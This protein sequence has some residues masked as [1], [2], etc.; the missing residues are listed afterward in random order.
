MHCPEIT[1]AYGQTE[2]SPVITQSDV[3]DSIE[4]RVGTVGP[5]LPCTEVKI[6]NPATGETMPAGETG[7]LCA[8]GYMV[9]KGY[10]GNPEA[11]AEAID[12]EGW[13]HTGDLA[14][15]TPDGYFGIRGRSKDMIIRGG[16]NIYPREIEEFLYTHPAVSDV[17]VFGL[18][19]EKFGEIVCAWIRIKPGVQATEESIREYCRGR[20]AHYKIPA[21]V[22]V[23]EEFPMTVTG[24]LQKFRMREKEIE[25]RNLQKAASIRTA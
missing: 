7:E 14:V 24:K 21:Y 20:I 4:H 25:L 16:E 19:D 9:M 12:A 2:A 15:M 1:I 10:D 11:T 8:R 17:S 23:V 5:A 22:R 6:I 3:N 18:P 13:L